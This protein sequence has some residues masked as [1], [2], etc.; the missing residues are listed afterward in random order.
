MSQETKKADRRYLGKIKN[1]TTQ[2]GSVFQKILIENPNP[3]SEDGTP[4]K[5][6][7]GALLWIDAD[8]RQFQVKQMDIFVP[9][10]GMGEAGKH[11]F[12][13]NIVIDLDKETSTNEK[14]YGDVTLLSQE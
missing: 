1:I 2:T 13:A 10:N 5:Y 9:Q 11:G 7:K 3:Q 14:G 12:V 8:G 6:Y 4:N